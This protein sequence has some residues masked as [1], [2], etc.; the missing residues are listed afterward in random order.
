MDGTHWDGGRK[1]GEMKERE[2]EGDEAGGGGVGKREEEERRKRDQLSVLW[3]FFSLDSL[4]SRRLR[5]YTHSNLSLFLSSLSPS[6]SNRSLTT[7]LDEERREEEERRREREGRREEKV[8]RGGRDRERFLFPLS[9][10]TILDKILSTLEEEEREKEG[11]R[12]RKRE[13]REEKEEREERGIERMSE[14]FVWMSRHYH[15]HTLAV[16]DSV[17]SKVIHSCMHAH[18]HTQYIHKHTKQEPKQLLS[19]SF[20]RF[21]LPFYLS[22]LCI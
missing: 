15:T 18:T 5:A 11:G 20:L 19:L 1:E 3:S 22:N 13:E 16:K 12:A 9:H 17:L 10:E 4:S 21:L 6:L 14:C 8:E 2:G 7:P